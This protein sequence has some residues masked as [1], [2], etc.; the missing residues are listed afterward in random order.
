MKPLK[1]IALIFIILALTLGV[2]FYLEIEFPVGIE[3]YLKKEYYTQFGPL[4]ISIELLIAGIYLF[5]R[6]VNANF[7]LAL[8]GFT[9]LL[10]SIFNLLGLFSS[11][12]PIYA[13]ILFI[14]CALLS[15]WLAFTDTFKL[16]RISIIGALMSFIIGNTIELFFNYW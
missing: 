2:L 5:K 8:F 4:A 15:L 6:H 1:I 14:C 10:D 16:G 12:L 9:V 3:A 13:M 11:M 7:T